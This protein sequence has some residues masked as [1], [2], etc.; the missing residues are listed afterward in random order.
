MGREFRTTATVI[1]KTKLGESDMIVRLLSD[2][3]SLVEAVA[4]GARKPQNA[5]SSR[6][7]LL[8]H[9]EVLLHE[10]KS[11]DIVKDCRLIADMGSIGGDPFSLSSA[12]VMAEFMTKTAQRDL[13]VPRLHDLLRMGLSSL[14]SSQQAYQLASSASVLLKGSAILG[15]RPQL[16]S[17]VSC[18]A[19]IDG[20]APR[21]MVSFEDGGYLCDGC[22]GFSSA[23]P[24]GTDT[25]MWSQWLIANPFSAI[26][27]SMLDDQTALDIFDF[28]VSWAENIFDMRLKSAKS[29]RAYLQ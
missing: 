2:D 7:E 8:N 28:A 14:G 24:V 18:G 5:L 11:L 16:A 29:L 12:A 23:V 6:L 20:E 4:K 1:G 15:F 22:L 25:V 21:T 10:G 26:Q 17:C 13:C 9:V 27:D 3:G 19:P